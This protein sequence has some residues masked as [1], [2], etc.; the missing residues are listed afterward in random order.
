MFL[1]FKFIGLGALI[2]LQLAV[3]SQALA[4]NVNNRT[5]SAVSVIVH[6][7]GGAVGKDLIP[8][9]KNLA[10]NGDIRKLEISKISPTGVPV[11]EKPFVC[12]GIFGSVIDI[13]EKKE[14]KNILECK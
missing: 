11:S 6:L 1:K 2:A 13:V 7:Y 10:V 12:D 3:N 5:D 14:D 4:I 8:L 9:G